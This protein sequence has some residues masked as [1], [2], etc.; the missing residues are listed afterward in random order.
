MNKSIKA[1]TIIELSPA[2]QLRT[3]MAVALDVDSVSDRDRLDQWPEIDQMEAVVLCERHLG[4]GET[5]EDRLLKCR[6]VGD[7]VAIFQGAKA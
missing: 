5:N 4:L 3:L 7:L 6:T 1:A 2:D